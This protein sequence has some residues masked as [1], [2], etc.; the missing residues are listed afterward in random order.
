MEDCSIVYISS[1]EYIVPH[2]AG[3]RR[4]IDRLARMQ[5]AWLIAQFEPRRDL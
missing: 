1:D 4:E 2:V 3:G 5:A